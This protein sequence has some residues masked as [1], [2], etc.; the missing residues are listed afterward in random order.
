MSESVLRRSALTKAFLR[1]LPSYP[2]DATDGSEGMMAQ[3]RL[4]PN[5]LTTV[6]TRRRKAPAHDDGK[7]F[8]ALLSRVE[9]NRQMTATDR[10]L[11]EAGAYA[12]QE[13]HITAH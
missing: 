4:A 13:I 3:I 10:S 5:T 12:A 6:P 7:P 8:D 2:D 11:A 1:G 9:R